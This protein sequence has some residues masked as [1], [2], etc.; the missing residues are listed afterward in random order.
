[1]HRFHWTGCLLLAL[2]LIY[3]VMSAHAI[4]TQWKICYDI[5]ATIFFVGFLLYRPKDES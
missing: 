3:W 5:Q 2:F 1:M 4:N